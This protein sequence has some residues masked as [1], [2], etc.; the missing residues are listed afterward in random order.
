MSLYSIVTYSEKVCGLQQ[1]Q[2]GAC[3]LHRER[4]VMKRFCETVW[5]I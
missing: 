3:F 5:F 1:G 4:I 2:F